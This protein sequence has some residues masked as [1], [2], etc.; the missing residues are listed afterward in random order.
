MKQIII[1]TTLFVAMNFAYGQNDGP[2]EITSQDL[3]KINGDIEKQIPAF[4]Q[5]LSKRELTPGQ[6]EFSLD[7]FRIEQLVSKQMD[8]DY[9]TV[10]MRTAV[11]E[12]TSSY[13]KLMNKYYNKLLKALKPE[14]KQTLVAAQRAWIVYRDAEAKLIGAMTKEE[15]SGGGTIQSMIATGSYSDLVI[16][17]ALE[18]FNYYDEIV[19]EK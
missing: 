18:I 9:S 7:T 2:R 10:G 15:Y 14:D 1:V 5:K 3:Q 6:I 8:I 17:R 16:K 4:K 11:N 12:K 19:K 13:D